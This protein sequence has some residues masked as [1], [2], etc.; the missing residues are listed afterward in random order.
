MCVSSSNKAHH[1]GDLWAELRQGP[2][3]K[4]VF[5]FYLCF[6]FYIP[7]SKVASSLLLI[8]CT[9]PLLLPRLDFLMNSLFVKR[10]THQFSSFEIVYTMMIHYERYSLHYC[11]TGWF[12]NLLYMSLKNIR[13]GLNTFT[14]IYELYK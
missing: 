5:I 4:I 6:L 8:C 3:M 11:V 9:A 12:L 7:S 14:I 1:Q 2:A 10:R 13:C